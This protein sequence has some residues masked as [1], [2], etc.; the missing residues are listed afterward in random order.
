MN[1]MKSLIRKCFGILKSDKA[2][3]S[4]ANRVDGSKLPESGGYRLET[5]PESGAYR[6]ET[7]RHFTDLVTSGPFRQSAAHSSNQKG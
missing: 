6:M 7:T 2:Q 3:P 5:L 1:C 4:F